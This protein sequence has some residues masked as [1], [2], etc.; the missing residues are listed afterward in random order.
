MRRRHPRR[1]LQWSRSKIDRLYGKAGGKKNDASEGLSPYIYETLE[2]PDKIRTLQLHATKGKIECSLRQISFLDSGYQ[3]LSYVWGG[4]EKL[5]KA[6]VLDDDGKGLGYIPLTANVQ[7]AL[8]DLRDAKGV[9]SKVFWIDQIC[10]NQQ[11][12]EKNHQVALMGEIYRNASRVIT[13]VGSAAEDEEEEACGIRLLQRLDTHFAPNYELLLITKSLYWANQRRSEFPVLEL[14]QGLQARESWV[15]DEDKYVSQGWKWLLQVAHG[16]ASR[17]FAVIVGC[18]CGRIFFFFLDLFPSKYVDRFWEEECMHASQTHFDIAQSVYTLWSQR[19]SQKEQH[20]ESRKSL[21]ELMSWH[22]HLHCWDPRDRIFAMLA[23]SSDASALGIVPDY[24]DSAAVDL[25]FLD[26]SVRILQNPE[27][28]SLSLLLACSWAECQAWTEDS[29]GSSDPAPTSALPSWSLGPP[30]SPIPGWSVHSTPHPRNSPRAPPYFRLDQTVLVL[31]GGVIDRI[32]MSTPVSFHSHS[33]S[34]G[35]A[36]E[37]YIQT[38]SQRLRSWTAVLIHLGVNLENVAAFSRALTTSINW[39]PTV[40]DG[41]SVTEATAFAFWSYFRQLANYVREYAC[42]VAMEDVTAT[43]K[44]CDSVMRELFALLF[45]DSVVELFHPDSALGPE[46]ESASDG[47]WSHCQIQGRSFCVTETGR[48]C[49]AMNQA[50]EGDMVAAFEGT[51]R[52]WILRPVGTKY[53][54]IGEAFVDGLMNGE[55]Y[56]GIDPDEVDYEI[57]LV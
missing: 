6:T 41:H 50:R 27:F 15:E 8:C 51:S 49:N 55:A 42:E 31:K 32:S 37:S 54:L 45:G 25:V 14:P 16:D 11:G 12:D 33:V 13:Y 57:E 19:Q 2:G 7:A 48:V 23:I 5:F 39:S 43:T 38:W 1:L 52:L 56:E 3:A 40:W 30:H 9:K 4:E 17:P 44:T 22:E 20:P 18:C 10:I 34:L 47:I 24:S 26:A 46:E 36:D 28:L 21:V 53:L 29:A 35:I